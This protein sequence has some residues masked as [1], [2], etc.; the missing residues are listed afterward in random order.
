MDKGSIVARGIALAFCAGALWPVAGA[1]A[2]KTASCAELVKLGQELDPK[3][4]TPVNAAGTR[5]A[6]PALFAGPRMEQVFGKPALSWTQEDMAA[7][8]KNTGDCSNEAKKAKKV[9]ETQALAVLWQGMGGLRSSLGAIAATDQKLAQQLKSL[10]EAQPVRPSLVVF[11]TLLTA[12]EGTA[13]ALQAV[14][15]SLKEHANRVNGWHPVQTAGLNFV[16]T[17]RDAQSASWAPIFPLIE[18]RLA[19]LRPWAIEDAATALNATPES[20]AGLRKL[21]QDLARIKL[22]LTGGLGAAELG[23]LD[24]VAAAR[25]DGIEEALSAKEMAQIDAVPATPQGLHMLR[26][27]QQSQVKAALSAPRVAAIDARIA[28]KREA[29]GNAV[30]DEQIK[31]LDRFPATLAG[32]GEIDAFRVTTGRGIEQLAGAGPAQKFREAATKRATKI[33]EESFPAFRKAIADMPATEQGLQAFDAAVAEIRGPVGT[34]DAPVRSKYLDTAAKRRE[35]IVAAV[36]KE[37]ARLAKLPLSGAVF[38]DPD[39]GAKLEFRSRT[40]VYLTLARD[41]TTE[42]SYEVDGDRLVIRTPR[43]NIV[44]K[45]DGAWLRGGGMDL[46][47]QAEK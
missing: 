24:K 30:A 37:N 14:D 3:Q 1:A 28:A 26:A 15:K 12:R 42:G 46:R 34:L 8:V 39:G 13:A 38:A 41:M 23:G 19:E 36:A 43:D 6:L 32:L 7:A 18:K 9:P 22:E 16:T 44:M 45:R 33:G 10:L 47:R 35:E 17:L 5:I 20:I 21:P 4:T 27:A 2:L 25:R 31:E 11:T 29:V 40:K